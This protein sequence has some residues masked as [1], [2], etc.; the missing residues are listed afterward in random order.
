MPASRIFTSLAAAALLTACHSGGRPVSQINPLHIAHN[1]MTDHLLTVNMGALNNSKQWGSASMGDNNEH[2]VDVSVKLDN[3]P[4]GSERAYVGKG[5]CDPPPAAVWKPLNPV[6]HGKS[7]S[8]IDGVTVGDIKKGRYS[9][10]VEG[11]GAK[12][13]SCGDFEL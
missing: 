3:A 1:Y 9:L 12:P 8:K 13:V 5:N 6:M 2:G 4:N 11:Q 10:V 7:K